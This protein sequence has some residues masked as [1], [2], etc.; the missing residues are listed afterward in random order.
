M[1]KTGLII[2]LLALAL[3]A[4]L[5]GCRR[6]AGTPPAAAP[7]EAE[8]R[9]VRL[10]PESAELAGLKTATVASRQVSL[11]IS[12]F[13]L[14]Q[15]NPRFHH[16]L[17]ARVPGRIETIRAFE[18]THVR[19][20]QELLTLYSPEFLTAQSELLQMLER[21]RVGERSGDPEEKKALAGLLEAA[22]KKLRFLGLSDEDV[23]ALKTR[24]EV[25]LLLPVRA[26]IDGLINECPA[27][28][29]NFVEAG[30]LLVEISDL[31]TVWVEAR[32]FEK[33]IARLETG[34]RA[35]VALSALPGESFAGRLTVIGASVDEAGRTAK[36]VVEVPN[37]GE[38]LKPGMS[39]E[40]TLY[41]SRTV[42]VLAVPESAV[43]KVEGR[44]VVF[45]EGPRLTFTEREVKTGRSL[46][47][48]LEVLSGLKE[49]E[50]V[51]TE[52]SL[53]LK[54]ELLKKNL[55]GE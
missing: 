11:P 6:Q 10:S 55:E 7:E 31:R 20:G 3:M 36:A 34:L 16:H 47:G 39:A 51:A 17:T 4:F 40:V 25:S 26:P 32:V 54:S 19:A 52:G 2:G 42:P 14:V 53:A 41:P 1:K 22:E 13:G 12:A 37:P 29:G 28:A 5:E 18:G 50:V 30:T 9:T 23:Q 45:V 38:R 15:F 49:G 44:D 21:Q 27:V 43:R 35:E 8:T 24:K 48:A 33:D 46:G